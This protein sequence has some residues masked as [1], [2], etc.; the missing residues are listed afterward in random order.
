M[1][2]SLYNNIIVTW[3]Y[4]VA[5]KILV[6]SHLRSQSLSLFLSDQIAYQSVGRRS[7]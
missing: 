4:F 2:S 6:H 1:S 5:F 3:M 7:M